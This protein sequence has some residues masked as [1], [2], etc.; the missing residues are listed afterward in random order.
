MDTNLMTRAT[1]MR[2]PI[3]V[4]LG[5]VVAALAAFVGFWIGGP[6]EPDDPPVRSGV[7]TIIDSSGGTVCIG[8]PDGSHS[9]C[10]RAPGVSLKQG[11]RIRYLLAPAD[12]ERPD[13]ATQQV[14][15]YVEVENNPTG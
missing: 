7:V 2:T 15:M 11:D 10:Y 5:V 8:D 14:L 1:I 12:A 6:G 13:W 9:E 4:W 3:P